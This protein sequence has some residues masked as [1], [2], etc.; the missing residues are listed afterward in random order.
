MTEHGDNLQPPPQRKR[1]TMRERATAIA[2]AL[3]A[4]LVAVFVVVLVFRA[5][6]HDVTIGVE[7][8][9]VVDIDGPEAIAAPYTHGDAVSLRI[10]SVEPIVSGFRYDLRYTAYGPGEH[11]LAPS[12]KRA[13]GTSPATQADLEISVA[14]LLAEDYS[15]ELYATPA[16]SVNLHTR[17]K[18]YM[19]LAW[20]AWALMLVP[21]IW[22][23]HKKRRR[24]AAAAPPPSVVER[25][26]TLLEQATRE[27]LSVEQ[28][29]DLEALLLAF[30]SERLGLSEE[31]LIAAIEQLRKHPQAG[32]QWNRIERWIHSPAATN[33]D[34]GAAQSVSTSSAVAKQLL[35]DFE[36]LN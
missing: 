29:A 17:Y 6:S 28:K 15:G 14:A 16:S 12:L 23:G 18:L 2:A 5:K 10:A 21:L 35:S 3:A 22:I 20:G 25:V 7:G 30:W 33:G 24:T 34:R 4:L 9:R 31:K 27:N 32:A 19:G 8:R 26:R 11:D 36:A 1:K 13:D